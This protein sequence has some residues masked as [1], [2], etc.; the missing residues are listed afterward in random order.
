MKIDNE[1][2]RGLRDFDYDNYHYFH[3]AVIRLDS[4]R[5][6]DFEFNSEMDDYYSRVITDRYMSLIGQGEV[7]DFKTITE[8]KK[9]ASR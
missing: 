9:K 4:V 6:I 7:L 5:P 2:V 1:L 3:L 8:K